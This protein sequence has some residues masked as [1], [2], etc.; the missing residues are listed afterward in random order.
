MTLKFL[1]ENLLGIK[2]YFAN[3]SYKNGTE[4]KQYDWSQLLGD[5]GGSLG[6]FTG[7]SFINV[8]EAVVYGYQISIKI[9]MWGGL[10]VAVYMKRILGLEN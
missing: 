6:L 8:L 1:R 10:A 9:I 7:H 2:V 3:L 5:I 4:Q